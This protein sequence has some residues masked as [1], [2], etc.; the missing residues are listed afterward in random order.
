MRIPSDPFKA[1]PV[2]AVAAAKR[3]QA[4]ETFGAAPAEPSIKVSVSPEARARSVGAAEERPVDMEKVERLRALMQR[5]EF[6][7][8][9]ARIADRILASEA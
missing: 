2:A 4:V 5:G 1:P 3:P 6:K 9:S 8:D 7:I